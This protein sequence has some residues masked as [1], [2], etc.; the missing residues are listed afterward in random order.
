MHNR[1]SWYGRNWTTGIWSDINALGKYTEWICTTQPLL[2]LWGVAL[3]EPYGQE[4][5]N[6]LLEKLSPLVRG[7]CG[8]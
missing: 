3:E 7:E 4:I 6:I 2:K 1:L 5:S 8:S